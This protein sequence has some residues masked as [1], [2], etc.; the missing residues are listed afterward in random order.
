MDNLPR[1]LS[2]G[3]RPRR[4]P[5]KKTVKSLIFLLISLS[6]YLFII[7]WILIEVLDLYPNHER[8]FTE[9]YYPEY[10]REM[11]GLNN[12]NENN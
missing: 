2:F 9:K 6:F 5:V 10:A 3:L 4:H 8:A 7:F 12:E 11:M 1:P